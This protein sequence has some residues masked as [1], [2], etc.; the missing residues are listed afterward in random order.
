MILGIDTASPTAS[1]ALVA[2]GKLVLEEVRSAP[3]QSAR[4][5][6]K[7]HGN[8]AEILLPLIDTVLTRGGLSLSEISAF[9]VSIGPGSFTGLRIGLST[10]K[11][12]AYG[13]EIPVI[14]VPTLLA[15]ATRVS[16]W[17]GLV[18]PIL[19]ARKK[20]VY[21]ALFREKAGTL[22]RLTPYL[23]SSLDAIIDKVR[24]L[25]DR[26]PALFIG[27]GIKVYGD[28]IATALG[29]R[30]VLTLGEGCPSTACAVAQLGEARLKGLE[31]DSVGTMIPLYIRPSEAE[32]K[33]PL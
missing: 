33:K 32:L 23:V 1:V 9:A 30:A 8:H 4:L 26:K 21:A 20:E 29:E 6:S 31:V 27:D 12:L 16:G 13:W 2:E 22:E 17:E 10:V 25:G 11:G 24:A 5:L 19:D 3:K 28:L 14:G 7:S 15:M 18:C